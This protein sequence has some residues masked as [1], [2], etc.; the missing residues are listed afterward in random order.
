MEGIEGTVSDLTHASAYI[1]VPAVEIENYAGRMSNPVSAILDWIVW[2]PV[3]V[4]LNRY[5]R[6]RNPRPYL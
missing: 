6:A 4:A 3:R 2:Q 5:R 1:T